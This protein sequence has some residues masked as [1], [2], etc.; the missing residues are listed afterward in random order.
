MSHYQNILEEELLQALQSDINSGSIRVISESQQYADLISQ[1]FPFVG[2]KID[3]SK[4]PGHTVAQLDWRKGYM[5]AEKSIEKLEYIDAIF[6]FFDNI[7]RKTHTPDVT[8][9]I[10]LGD[11]TM[12]IALQLPAGILR[13]HLLDVVELPQHT[14]IIP[15]DVS[16]CLT[17]TTEGY[18]DFGFRPD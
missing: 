16:W 10:V 3:W 9:L 17:Y 18:M 4:V 14:Y 5:H 11:G 12:D 8:D 13:K 2:N 1:N 6:S 15:P 7:L